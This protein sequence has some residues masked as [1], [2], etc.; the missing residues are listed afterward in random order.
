MAVHEGL[1]ER[2][3]DVR[4]KGGIGDES[5]A[6]QSHC[7]WAVPPHDSQTPQ[8][9]RCPNLKWNLCSYFETSSLD[10]FALVFP[11]S[12]YHSQLAESLPFSLLPLGVFGL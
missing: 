8:L 12:L 10:T 7:M 4:A 11:G 6:W 2:K 9:Q 1:S 3:E 5:M